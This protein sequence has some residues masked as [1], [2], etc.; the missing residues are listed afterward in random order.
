MGGKKRLLDRDEIE[1]VRK[2]AEIGCTQDEIAYVLGI[3]E[4]TFRARL[5]DQPEVLEAYKTGQAHL[6]LKLRSLQIAAAEKGNSAMLI[7]LG[8]QLL[9]QSDKTTVEN[10][11]IAKPAGDLEERIQRYA[12]VFARAAELA[13][14]GSHESGSRGDGS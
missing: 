4:N 9:G 14:R 1:R 8:K 6:K 3:A 5:V 7:W 2:L 13:K 12:E 11:E 10:I